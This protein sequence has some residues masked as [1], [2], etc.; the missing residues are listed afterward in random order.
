MFNYLAKFISSSLAL[1]IRI[2]AAYLAQIISQLE[3][4]RKFLLQNGENERYLNKA[5]ILIKSL[6]VI[7]YTK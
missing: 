5:P 6:A 2:A 7:F 4:G 3:D 1:D